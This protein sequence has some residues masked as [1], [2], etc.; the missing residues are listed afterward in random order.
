MCIRDRNYTAYLDAN[1]IQ[2]NEDG[3]YKSN[4]TGDVYE[5]DEK[6]GTYRKVGERFNYVFSQ[7]HV[8][9]LPRMFSEDQ[10]VMQNY[11]CL[12]YTS[13]CV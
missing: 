11:I 2:K 6:T 12:L 8:S 3:S 13:R 5:K 10:D 1:G 4:K 9:F 7:D